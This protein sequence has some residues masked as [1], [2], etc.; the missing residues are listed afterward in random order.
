M[1]YLWEDY[2]LKNEYV[3]ALQNFCPYTEIFQTVNNVSRVNLLYRFS[4]VRDSLDD[5]FES[6]EKIQN[7]IGRNGFDTLFHLLANIDFFAGISLEDFQMMHIYNE[8][9]SGYYGIDTDL[10]E[11]LSFR[12]KYKLLSYMLLRRNNEGRDNLFFDC[13]TELFDAGL[14]FSEFADTYIIQIH[15]KKDYIWEGNYTSQELYNLTKE[16]LCDFW[17]N[18]EV[19]WEI[20]IGIVDDEMHID[21]IQII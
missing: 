11:R 15:G 16:L 21:R 13:I 7:S 1:A 8:I 3:L 5:C 18:T 14:Y 9:C 2:D 6:K 20:P 4:K 17:V 12:H 19:Y 10:F